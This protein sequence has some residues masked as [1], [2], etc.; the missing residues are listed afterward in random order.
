M[1]SW[2]WSNL[3]SKC[4]WGVSHLLLVIV[5]RGT[6]EA[7]TARTCH[8]TASPNTCPCVWKTRLRRKVC[9]CIQKRL[10]YGDID[11]HRTSKSRWAMW[12]M[13]NGILSCLLK[14]PSVLSQI[15]NDKINVPLIRPYTLIWCIILISCWCKTF[16]ILGVMYKLNMHPIPVFL[17]PIH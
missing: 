11:C 7:A 14:I 9:S 15:I 2:H 5:A 17:V 8:R 1:C 6:A 12:A 4:L 13:L 3:I 16:S 10:R